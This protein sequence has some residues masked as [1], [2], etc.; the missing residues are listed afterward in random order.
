[1]FLAIDPMAPP[2]WLIFLI[3]FCFLVAFIVLM[4]TVAGIQ[5]LVRGESFFVPRDRDEGERPSPARR[6]LRSAPFRKQFSRANSVQARSPRANAEKSNV[7][8]VQRFT[9][10]SDVQLYTPA[11]MGDLPTSIDE[12]Q[13]LA[14]TIALY[15]KRPN[16]ELAILEAWGETKGEGEGY[17]RASSLFDAA[18][19]DTARAAAKAKAPQL[20]AREV[21]TA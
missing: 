2:A 9:D 15:A 3:S 16:K 7:Q 20:A 14:H 19:S 6:S 10:R 8:S 17:K 21:E 4:I 11:I 12:L 1:M 13:R 18:M 5:R